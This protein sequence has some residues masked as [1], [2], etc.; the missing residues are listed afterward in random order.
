[1]HFNKARLLVLTILALNACKTTQKS[2]PP[3]QDTPPSATVIT[4]KTMTNTDPFLTKLLQD[5][6]NQWF[7]KLMQEK[8]SLKIQ[9]IYT[10]I[11]RN[12]NNKPVFK[13]YH[14]NT[15][16]QYFYPASTVKMPVALLAL[17]KLNENKTNGITAESTMITEAAFSKQTPVY[18]DPTTPDGKPTIAQYIRKIFMVSDND[19]YNRLYEFLGQEY[20]NRQ[21]Q[22]KG[23]SSSA[24]LHRLEISMTEEENRQTNPIQFLD[25]NGKLLQ[26]QNAQRSNYPYPLRKDSVGIGYMSGNVLKPQAMDFS[27]KNRI[28]LQD[29]N[30]ML[31]AVLFP[32]AVS[33]KHRFNLTADDYKFVKKYMSQFPHECKSPVYDSSNY[34]DSYVKFLLYGSEKGSLPKQVRIFNKVGDAYG[35]LTDVAY[36]VDFENNIEFMLSATIY[37]NKDGILN[38]NKYDY[39]TVGFPFMKTLGTIIYQ[40]ELKR[41]RKHKPDLSAFKMDYDQ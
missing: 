10:Q 31:K 29:L 14:F 37:C 7:T 8:D 17:Q 1:M 41:E 3:V 18:N 40:H 2:T 12:A 34:W 15:G 11:D 24:I 13:D 21:L 4:K 27:K 36:V 39:D 25:A 23:Y 9:I 22:Q 30:N 20:I 19:A 35:F 38:D 16:D 26:T 5:S 32:E 33:E 28:S 6:N